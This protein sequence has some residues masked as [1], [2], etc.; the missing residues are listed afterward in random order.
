MKSAFVTGA[1][2]FVGSHL[3]ERLIKDGWKVKCLVRSRNNLKW[4]KDLDIEIVEGDLN[5]TEALESGASDVDT[6]FHLA[7]VLYGLKESDF[8][9]GNVTGIKNLLSAVAKNKNLKRFIHVSTQ[10][11]TGPAKSFN[12]PV[13]DSDE[14]RPLTWYGQ[15]KLAA[16]KEVLS[17]QDKFP[18]TIIRPGAVYGPRDYAIF[19]VF[20]A[21][22]S[23]FNLKVGREDKYVNF[24]HV[25]DLVD[26]IIA[27]EASE[28]TIGKAYFIVNDE[29][30]A[31]D[32]I[33][34]EAIKAY[35]KKPK[36]IIVPVSIIRIVAFFSELYGKVFNKVVV[37]NRQ[38]LIEITQKYWLASNEQAKS[39]F[40]F[41]PKYSTSE[42]IRMTAEWY[43]ENGWL[44]Y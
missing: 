11:V 30:D 2:G 44:K 28:K 39:D 36:N 37:L 4:L 3:V 17:Y 33:A 38:K 22:L 21:S 25:N 34:V 41:S 26:A 24:I 35:G 1:T 7:G 10:A 42:G 6:V 23:G 29:K 8:Y 31:Q 16:E 20:K 9:E 18:I 40:G 13:R 27:A 43:K 12:D 14:K 15:S 32:K 19:Q 5:A